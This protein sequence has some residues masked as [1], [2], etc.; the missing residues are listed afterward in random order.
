VI[1]FH[2]YCVRCDKDQYPA[3]F[4]PGGLLLLLFRVVVATMAEIDLKIAYLHL[5]TMLIF[6]VWH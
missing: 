2:L 6:R 1:N 4:Y 3:Y 5:A